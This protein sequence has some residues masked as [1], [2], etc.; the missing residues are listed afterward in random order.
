MSHM[1]IVCEGQLHG[2]LC[3]NEKTEE[4]NGMTCKQCDAN[5]MAWI[6]DTEE[7]GKRGDN[8]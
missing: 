6:T 7:I 4:M 1:C 2:Y 3:S 8:E 5:A